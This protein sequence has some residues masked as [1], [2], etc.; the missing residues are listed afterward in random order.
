MARIV[1]EVADE[2]GANAAVA[3]SK[4]KAYVSEKADEEEFLA[5]W[6]VGA[7]VFEDEP[8]QR[9]FEEAVAE[10]NL[11]LA[12]PWR[13]RSQRVAKN[14]KI[15]TD[16]GIEITSPRIRHNPDFIEF[17]S[18]PNGLIQIGEE[19]RQHREPVA[20]KECGGA[21]VL[22][23]RARVSCYHGFE[24][25]APSFCLEYPY[26]TQRRSCAALLYRKGK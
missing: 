5:P 19:Y 22:R 7:E 16:T 12:C 10:E 11:P 15:R 14:H 17:V 26:R 23:G 25:T 2:F 18:T 3:L 6:E 1:E 13:R 20:E 4:A 21:F 9:R 8:L 24:C